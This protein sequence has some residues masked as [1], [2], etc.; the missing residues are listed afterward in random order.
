[1]MSLN[2]LASGVASAGAVAIL[3][4]SASS[5][6]LASC[7]KDKDYYEALAKLRPFEM[8]MRERW[9]RDDEE[10]WRKLPARAWPPRQPDAHELDGLE[11]LWKAKCADRGRREE[12]MVDNLGKRSC[13]QIE[14]DI[15]TT[16]VFNNL[17]PTNGLERYKTL[18]MPSSE[19]IK[20]GD[21]A[22]VGVEAMVAVGVMLVEGLGVPEDAKRG[23]EWIKRAAERQSP[24]GTFELATLCYTGSLAGGVA[25]DERKA[26]TLFSKAAEM[27]HVG[28]TY[29]KGDCLLDGVG[30]D[31][32]P[33]AAVPLIYS[34][35]EKGHRFARQR[36]LQL[37]DSTKMDS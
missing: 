6:S 23:V 31:A 13:G 1:V 18:A 36:I 10:G 33:G 21:D 29:M 7:T 15:A 34:A 9:R 16:L 28:A 20:D 26:F 22:N 35:A 11:R 5:R 30:V 3:V 12:V 25:E 17:D 37:L 14:F 19:D 8:N 24:Q 4:S 2:R 27:G 32:V